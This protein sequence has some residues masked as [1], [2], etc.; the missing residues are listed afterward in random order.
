MSKDIQKW[1][2]NDLKPHP[3]QAA[4]FTDLP[5]H[6]LRTRPAIRVYEAVSRLVAC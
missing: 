6:L 4:F 3:R 1:K 5:F 2:V